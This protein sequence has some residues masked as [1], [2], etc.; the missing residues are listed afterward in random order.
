MKEKRKMQ[1][2]FTLIELLVVIAIIAILASMLLPALNKAREKGKSISCLSQ[3]KQLGLAMLSYQSDSDDYFVPY[4]EDATRP[5]D[6][7]GDYLVKKNY[8]PDG[9]LLEC[10]SHRWKT[11]KPG[12][13][14]TWGRAWTSYGYNFGYVGGSRYLGGSDISNPA[15]LSQIRNIG[16]MLMDTKLGINGTEG[17]CRVY[18]Y[19]V[20]TQGFPDTRH[21]GSLNILYTDG[22][23]SAMRIRIPSSPY[24]ELRTHSDGLPQNPW[25]CGRK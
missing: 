9:K 22:H 16:Y 2:N 3:Q 17:A 21:G 19:A 20:S 15:K 10:P 8:I 12:A 24:N 23:A 11:N 5:I 25:T 18:P 7:W 14:N 6:Y 13:Y 4:M 1:S